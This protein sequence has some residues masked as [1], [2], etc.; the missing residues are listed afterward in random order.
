MSK[1]KSLTRETAVREYIKR[2]RMRPSNSNCLK[3]TRKAALSGS[4][5]DT[6]LSRCRKYGSAS[7]QKLSWWY[8]DYKSYNVITFIF[9][10]YDFRIFEI[11]FCAV[12]D[13]ITT[14]SIILSEISF[15]SKRLI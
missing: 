10:E 7:S 9:P 12:Y 3:S 1:N 13:E 5:S 14:V 4:H 2:E 6:D 11:A 8:F 15:A